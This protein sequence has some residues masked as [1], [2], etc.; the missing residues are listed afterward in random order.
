[1]ASIGS[2]EKNHLTRWVNEVI[3]IRKTEN[4]ERYW[5]TKNTGRWSL[6]HVWA[7]DERNATPEHCI[8]ANTLSK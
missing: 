7:A 2:K 5:K 3:W 1:M 8:S 6:S 4:T